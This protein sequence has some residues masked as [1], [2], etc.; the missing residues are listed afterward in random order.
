MAR[1]LVL[2]LDAAGPFNLEA[3]VRLLQRRPVNRVDVWDAG[4]YY[5]VLPVAGRLLLLAT[6][7]PGTIARPDLRVRIAGGQ[8][9]PGTGARIRAALHR[10][11]GLGHD[12]ATLARLARR[13]PM[14]KPLARAL[15]GMRPPRFPGLFEAFANVIPFQQVSLDAGAAIVARLVEQFGA[16]LSAGGRTWFAFPDAKTVAAAPV[17]ALRRAGLSRSRAEALHGI[18]RRIAAGDLT[19]ERLESL[20]SE[21]A[22]AALRLLPGIGPWSAGLLLLRGLGRTDVVPG[23]D[24]GVARGLGRLLGADRSFSYQEY[25][26]RFG[27][28]KG[29]LYF[30]ALG[31]QLLERGLLHPAAGPSRRA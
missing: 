18:A 7:N 28:A 5:R 16:R 15:R 19:A 26:E 1:T 9:P 6:E 17:D 3:T 13:E 4:T 22:M 2:K 10:V 27:A 31:A 8:P 29:W 21:E 12:P 30:L 14:L 24:V 20:G 11:L 23:G 25:A